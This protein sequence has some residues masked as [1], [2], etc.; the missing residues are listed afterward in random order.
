VASASIPS[1][2]PGRRHAVTLPEMPLF[3]RARRDHYPVDNSRD[4]RTGFV[5]LSGSYA[6]GQIENSIKV[7]SEYLLD[8]GCGFNGLSTGGTAATVEEAKVAMAKAFRASLA[9]ATRRQCL[10]SLKKRSTR[11]RAR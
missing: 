4:R 3:L 2:F 9:R 6:C 5:A 1:D 7:R 10:I 11:L 8:W